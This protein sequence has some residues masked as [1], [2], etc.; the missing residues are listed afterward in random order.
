MAEKKKLL[1]ESKQESEALEQEYMGNKKR[2][3]QEI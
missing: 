3:Q 2:I 1:E